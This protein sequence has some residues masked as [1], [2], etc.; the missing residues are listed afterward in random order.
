MQRLTPSFYHQ[1]QRRQVTVSDVDYFKQMLFRLY[2]ACHWHYIRFY[3]MSGNRSGIS[4]IAWCWRFRGGIN[5]RT[6]AG[7][8]TLRTQDTSDA[9][10]PYRS[11]CQDSGHLQL[12]TLPIVVMDQSVPMTKVSRYFGTRSEVSRACFWDRSILG[13]KCPVTHELIL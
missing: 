11:A 4:L 6:W 1:L 7:N 3:K 12:I 10:N 9:Q 13:P 8:T 2:R 5:K